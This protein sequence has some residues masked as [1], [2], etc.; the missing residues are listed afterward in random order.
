MA[1]EHAIG[2]ARVKE[3]HPL[4]PLGLS[5]ITL[6]IYALY[7]YYTL[8]RELRDLG[9]E[10]NP[11]MALLAITLGALVI[12]PP[13]VSMYN[14]AERIRR[15]QERSGAPKP[16]SPVL[17]LLMLIIPIVNIFQTAYLQSGMNRAIQQI[18][19]A[20]AQPPSPAHLAGPPQPQP[21]Q[22]PPTAEGAGTA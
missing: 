15:V 16:I 22:A 2:A 19:W 4:A 12:V 13:I 7:W 6:G 9:E 21:L 14:T 18:V 1:T 17:A 3:R 11:G 10:N 8:N 5:I 20:R